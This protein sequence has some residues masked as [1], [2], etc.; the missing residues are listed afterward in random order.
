[1]KALWSVVIFFFV[2]GITPATY[3]HTIFVDGDLSDWGIAVTTFG[4]NGNNWSSPYPDVYVSQEDWVGNNGYVGPGFGGQPYDAEA[5]L[6]TWDAQNL[7]LALA[8]G[9]NL[10]GQDYYGTT[11]YPGDLLIDLHNDH[12]Y[13]L[14][15]V[16]NNGDRPSLT[17]G[18]Y[19]IDSSLA[20]ENTQ[21]YAASDPFR[22]DP[23]GAFYTYIASGTSTYIV[24][25]TIPRS[26]LEVQIP[27]DA[28][29]N[30][31]GPLNVHWT[32]WCGNDALDLT[33]VHT[34]EPASFLLVGTALIFLI[35]WSHRR[36]RL[37]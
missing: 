10:Q 33:A 19:Q 6:M 3:G 31:Y 28:L 5:L 2:L 11:T 9:F 23:N 26:V 37:H 22:L 4:A 29:G 36:Y 21:Y 7:Y 30:Y 34:P 16:F 13:D 12:S 17:P 27:W 32:M 8:T 18:L 1:M 24:D 35:S 14:A 15:Y 20:L 25:S